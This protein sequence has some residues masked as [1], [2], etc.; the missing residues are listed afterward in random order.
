MVDL[1]SYAGKTIQLRFRL[2]ADNGGGAE[3]WYVDDASLKSCVPA[4]PEYGVLL[5]PALA[6]QVAGPGQSAEY[7]LTLTNTGSVEDTFSFSGSGSGWTVTLPGPVTLAA[8][9]HAD[10][11]V[12]VTPLAGAMGTDVLTVTVTSLAD[13]TKTDSSVLTTTALAPVYIPFI[14]R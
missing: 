10:V 4:G 1:D 11:T 13:G 6:A 7:T 12:S 8:G 2:G 5:S 3:G 14:L 9:A